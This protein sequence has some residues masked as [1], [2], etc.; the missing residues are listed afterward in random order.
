M[1]ADV[2]V[3]ILDLAEV[4]MLGTTVALALEN[5][6]RDARSSKGAVIVSGASTE[7]HDLLGS[8]GVL[9]GDGV[10]SAEN[11]RSA[12]VMALDLVKEQ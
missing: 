4:S 3:L 5:V 1:K 9:E 11:R 10:H 7:V 2:Q 8:L 6:I 12:L